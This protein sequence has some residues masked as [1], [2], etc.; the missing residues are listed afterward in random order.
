MSK[1]QVQKPDWEVLGQI[2]LHLEGIEEIDPA[3]SPTISPEV[4]R[5]LS[6][7]ARQ[8]FEGKPQ[9]E[10]YDHYY[11]L[12]SHGWPWRVACYIA[13]A[14]S[15]RNA[16]VPD[17]QEKL[18][19]Q[20][21]GLTSDRQIHTWRTKN[22]AIDETV[23]LMQSAPLFEHRADFFKAMIAVGTSNDYKGYNDRKM[24]LEMLGDYTPKMAVD[25]TRKISV[26]DLDDLNEDQLRELSK[27]ALKDAYDPNSTPTTDGLNEVDS[28]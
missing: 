12:R 4:A 22:P 14:S 11:D 23:A 26:D 25:E 3:V 17:S 5:V 27:Y 8:A 20:Y 1:R 28:D 16:R 13:W 7:Q 10:W 9:P 24:A 6:E 2:P 21:L 15:P 18:A 19:I